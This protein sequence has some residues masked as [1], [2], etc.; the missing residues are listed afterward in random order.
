MG[1][2][3]VRY[4]TLINKSINYYEDSDI[5]IVRNNEDFDDPKWFYT[6][7]IDFKPEPF[8]G[9]PTIFKLGKEEF[10]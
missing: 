5:N 8:L 10:K 6:D 2:N 3:C 4:K 1:R 9:S 7:M